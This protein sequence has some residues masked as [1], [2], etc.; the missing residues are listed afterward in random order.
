MA[1]CTVVGL[2]ASS[3]VP[4]FVRHAGPGKPPAYALIGSLNGVHVFGESHGVTLCSTRTSNATLTWKT[5][6]DSIRLVLIR[7]SEV[8]GDSCD[9]RLLD[10]MFASLVLIQGLD[11]LTSGTNIERLKREIRDV[12]SVS[13][14]LI[15]IYFRVSL[16]SMPREQILRVPV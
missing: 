10:L 12:Q 15:N 9:N 4:L 1:W 14:H 2:S 8:V 7:G 13:Y 6:H 11:N 3:G 16:K 5:Y